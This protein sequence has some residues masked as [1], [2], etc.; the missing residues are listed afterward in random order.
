MKIISQQLTQLISASR[1]I[2]DVVE[3]SMYVKTLAPRIAYYS[4][5]QNEA[6]PPCE[7]S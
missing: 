1:L 3:E 5:K 2:L 6:A 7:N 4:E